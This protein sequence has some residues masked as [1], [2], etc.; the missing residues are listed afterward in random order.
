MVGPNFFF[1][2]GQKPIMIMGWKVISNV[3]Y[4]FLILIWPLDRPLIR[5]SICEKSC[6]NLVLGQKW[7]VQTFQSQSGLI[8]KNMIIWTLEP[9]RLVQIDA[10]S[11]RSRYHTTSTS[12][13]WK[14]KKNHIFSFLT[15]FLTIFFR[16]FYKSCRKTVKMNFFQ[17]K[18]KSMSRMV[19]WP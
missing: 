2:F 7:H 16:D 1:F 19:I 11:Y 8:S 14:P 4:Q 9:F 18:I 6:K 3:L 5:F 10:F 13:V 12:K 17:N 15:I